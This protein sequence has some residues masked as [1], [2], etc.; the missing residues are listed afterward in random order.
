MCS[1]LACPASFRENCIRYHDKPKE[2]GQ[3]WFIDPPYDRKKKD[4]NY[5]LPR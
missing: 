5:F 2:K 4:C 3:S 1:G